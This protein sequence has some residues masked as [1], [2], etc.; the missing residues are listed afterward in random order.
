[1]PNSS[2]FLSKN[3]SQL[4]GLYLERMPIVG[5]FIEA[6]NYLRMHRI[7]VYWEWPIAQDFHLKD[8]KKCMVLSR[9][10]QKEKMCKS[11]GFGITEYSRDI[12]FFIQYVR[13]SLAV[14]YIV[15]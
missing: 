1:M 7:F 15:C 9:G 12:Q 10:F 11:A 3:D 4:H 8:V 14:N 2:G 5:F 6:Y 13:T